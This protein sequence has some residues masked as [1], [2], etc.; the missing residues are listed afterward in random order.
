[1]MSCTTLS[2]LGSFCALLNVPLPDLTAVEAERIPEPYHHLLVHDGDMTGRL[3]SYYQ[4]AIHLNTLRIMHLPGTLC[5]HVLL[6]T[7]DQHTVEF[8]AIQIHLGAFR[9]GALDAVLGCHQ[10]L[11]GILNAYGIPYRGDLG[12]FFSIRADVSL[13]DLLDIT[14]GTRLYGRFNRLVHGNGKTIA[15]VVEILPPS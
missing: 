6:Q 1:M 3:E 2:E 10:P 5:R 7:E 4:S 13:S 8:G 11:G 14:P 9:G 12:G 15:E